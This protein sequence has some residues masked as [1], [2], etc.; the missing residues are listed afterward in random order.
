MLAGFI[1]VRVRVTVMTIVSETKNSYATLT[2][3]GFAFY[4]YHHFKTYTRRFLRLV[5][6]NDA[7]VT[8]A[9]EA[10]TGQ[11]YSFPSRAQTSG[12]SV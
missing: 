11:E 4:S 7:V 3:L 2:L 8:C 6:S 9:D 12:D 5:V 1:H 10:S